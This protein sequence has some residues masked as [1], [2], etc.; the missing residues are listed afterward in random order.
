MQQLMWSTV[1]HRIVSSLTTFPAGVQGWAKVGGITL[2]TSTLAGIGAYSNGFIQDPMTEYCPPSMYQMYKPCSAI[3]FP[4]LVEELFWRA[5]L[6]PMHPYNPQTT[7]PI[8]T[9]VLIVHVLSHPIAANTCWKRGKDIFEDWKFLSLATIVL[10][11]AT[12]SY[13]VSGGSV[14]AAAITHG[15]PVALWRDYFGGERKL[16]KLIKGDG[17]DPG[18]ADDDDDDDGE[19]NKDP[20]MC[21]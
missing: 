1:S 2:A 4:S 9:A 17:D 8:A 21:Q 18:V 16:A 19:A 12:V 3:L 20:R 10:G 13:V 6:I 5:T 15:I 7:I 14:W 11:G